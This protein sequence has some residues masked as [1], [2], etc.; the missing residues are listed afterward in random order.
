M[1]CALRVDAHMYVCRVFAIRFINF[2]TIFGNLQFFFAKMCNYIQNLQSHTGNSY[3]SRQMIAQFGHTISFVH[4]PKNVWS[5]VLYVV[6]FL[7]FF[8]FV[9][10]FCFF[11]YCEISNQVQS[12]REEKIN[13]TFETG[14]TTFS[15][16]QLFLLHIIGIVQYCCFVFCYFNKLGVLYNTHYNVFSVFLSFF[17]CKTFYTFVYGL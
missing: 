7:M 1:L 6:L 12:N 9:S 4:N 2:Y 10:L 8:F 15:V 11:F 5:L 16:V 3:V 14:I 13:V 17:F